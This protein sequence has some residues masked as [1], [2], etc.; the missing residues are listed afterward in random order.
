MSELQEASRLNFLTNKII[1]VAIRVHKHL[2]PGLLE[3]TYESCLAHD[4]SKQKLRIERQKQLPV[5][6]EGVRLDCGYRVDLLVERIVIVEVKAVESVLPIHT[7]QLLSYLRLSGCK[8]GLLINFNVILL[9]S[10]IHRV[11]NNFPETLR[12]LR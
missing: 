1:E 5:I 10:G 8:V 11:V 7:S 2:G 4:L 9:K 3:S 12:T 6:Y